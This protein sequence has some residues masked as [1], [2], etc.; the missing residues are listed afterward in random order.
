MEK[1]ES[2]EELKDAIFIEEEEDH[3]A[4]LLHENIIN[5]SRLLDKKKKNFEILWINL[6]I[7]L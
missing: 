7:L 4:D 5:Q 6:V 3:N 2:E 1:I